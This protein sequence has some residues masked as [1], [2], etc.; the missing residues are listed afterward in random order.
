MP[1]QDRQRLRDIRR[2]VLDRLQ[3]LVDRLFAGASAAGDQARVVARQAPVLVEAGM[4]RRNGHLVHQLAE[5]DELVAQLLVGLDD[6]E[7][8]HL[9]AE[10]GRRDF[11]TGDV[12]A[13]REALPVRKALGYRIGFHR[14]L[15]RGT[16]HKGNGCDGQKEEFCV[17]FESFPVSQTTSRYLITNPPPRQPRFGQLAEGPKVKSQAFGANKTRHPSGS[18][19]DHVNSTLTLKNFI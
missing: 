8:R 9:V 1:L 14:R 2:G 19:S 7:Y 5:Q 18:A 10:I 17:H 15:R 6:G 11:A 3:G 16:G 12:V 13:G 4:R